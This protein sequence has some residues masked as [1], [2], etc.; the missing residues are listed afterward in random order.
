MQLVEELAAYMYYDQ[1]KDKPPKNFEQLPESEKQPFI[2]SAAKFL[3]SLDKA[4]KVP[5]D[6]GAVVD[7]KMT[8]EQRIQA[9]ALV[10]QKF[11]KGTKKRTIVTAYFPSLEL[12][13]KIVDG[14]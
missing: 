2:T 14:T 7:R 6:K 1:A 3:V 11:I 5:V 13:H 12:A 9:T 4:N 10:I 8:R